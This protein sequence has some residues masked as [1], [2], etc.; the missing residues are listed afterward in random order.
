MSDAAAGLAQKMNLHLRVILGELEVRGCAG[1][2]FKAH[3]TQAVKSIPGADL[4]GGRDTPSFPLHLDAAM[5]VPGPGF[6][7]Q[8]E[9]VAGVAEV[10]LQQ[11]A[12]VGGDGIGGDRRIAV[13]QHARDG[14]GRA[15]F[16][17][18]Q[19]EVE[20]PEI[21]VLIDEIGLDDRRAS[22]P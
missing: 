13:V 17:A 14:A 16:G 18:P 3:A 4:G 11:R 7:D 19:G 12:H 10:L 8:D 9:A 1:V 15:Q 21:I 20:S 2:A 22:V 6:G 5:A